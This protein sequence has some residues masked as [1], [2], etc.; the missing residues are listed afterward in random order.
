MVLNLKLQSKNTQ[1][2][3]N[4]NWGA[5]RSNSPKIPL[6]QESG[7]RHVRLIVWDDELGGLRMFAKAAFSEK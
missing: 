1:N 2:Q 7:E 5:F 4:K 6:R 3:F